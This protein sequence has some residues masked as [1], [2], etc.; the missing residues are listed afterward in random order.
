MIGVQLDEAIAG[1][2][3][4][5]DFA[6]LPV[7]VGTFYLRHLRVTAVR[8]ARLQLLVMADRLLVILAVEL[9]PRGAVY[10]FRAPVLGLVDRVERTCGG[11]QQGKNRYTT[12]HDWVGNKIGK[13]YRKPFV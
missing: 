10:P 1:R 8:I 11:Q 9:L 7:G 6:V 5:G 12:F 4:L 2:Q 13:L 3:R